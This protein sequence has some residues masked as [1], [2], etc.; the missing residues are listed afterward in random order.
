M[1]PDF[2]H[3]SSLTKVIIIVE[4]VLVAYLIYSLTKNVY[5]SYLVDSYI[6][7]FEEENSLLMAE[8]RKKTEDYLYFT[9][10]EYIDKIAKQNLGLIN[11]GEEVIIV[12]PDSLTYDGVA[13]SEEYSGDSDIVRIETRTNPQLWWDFFVR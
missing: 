12:S 1:S 7:G 5:N 10:E 8:N 11:P 4:F 6:E 2:S 3:T 9:S 13:G